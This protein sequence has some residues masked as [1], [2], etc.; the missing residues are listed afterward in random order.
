M[1]VLRSEYMP[2]IAS[3]TN[4]VDESC[5]LVSISFYNCE[6]SFGTAM[7]AKITH[8]E[9]VIGMARSIDEQTWP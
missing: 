8:K 1:F 4:N 3:R 2:A 5:D 9:S 7:I 6:K